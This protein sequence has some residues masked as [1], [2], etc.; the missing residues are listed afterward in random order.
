MKNINFIP[1][2]IIG[3]KYFETCELYDNITPAG[4]VTVILM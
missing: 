1:M 2:I 3:T 4:P